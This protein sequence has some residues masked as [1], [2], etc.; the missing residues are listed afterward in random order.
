MHS[1]YYVQPVYSDMFAA[2]HLPGESF[3][4]G[5][6]DLWHGSD[7]RR[8]ADLQRD[9]DV[10]RSAD[11]RRAADFAGRGDLPADAMPRLQLCGAAVPADD[12]V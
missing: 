12:R 5:N 10:S 7:L 4:S 2:F 1:G 8:I 9:K 3:V 11:V 6:S